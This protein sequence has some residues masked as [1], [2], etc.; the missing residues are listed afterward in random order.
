MNF[1][2]L[3][4][5]NLVENEDYVRKCLA[6]LNEDYFHQKPEKLTFKLINEYVGKYNT[7]PTKE[8]L[9]IELANQSLAD[10]LYQKT[11]DIINSLQSDDPTNGVIR[12]TETM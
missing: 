2:I 1:E 6:Y 3:I 11:Q 9:E 12:L 8:A 5:A 10:D 7:S 4:L